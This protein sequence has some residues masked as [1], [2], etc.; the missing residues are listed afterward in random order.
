MCK[1]TSKIQNYVKYPYVTNDLTITP[2]HICIQLRSTHGPSEESHCRS[3]ADP[4]PNP[5]VTN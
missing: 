3:V 1:K 5:N 4:K 2:D